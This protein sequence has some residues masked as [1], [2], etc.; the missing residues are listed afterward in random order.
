MLSCF[1]FFFSSSSLQKSSGSSPYGIGIVGV[2]AVGV[3]SKVL[4][5]NNVRQVPIAAPRYKERLGFRIFRSL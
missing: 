4:Q 5:C 3:A 2:G 1:F